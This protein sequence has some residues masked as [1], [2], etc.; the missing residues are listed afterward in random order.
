M[1]GPDREQI[2]NIEQG[3]E[4][5]EQ[6]FRRAVE[7]KDFAGLMQ[8]HNRMC[9]LVAALTAAWS[10]G[11]PTVFSRFYV[12]NR[13]TGQ[14]GAK[15]A[16]GTGQHP[17]VQ[18]GATPVAKPADAAAAAASA[19]AKP[20]EKPVEK[21]AAKPEDDVPEI[22]VL[23]KQLAELAS[24]MQ[25]CLEAGDMDGML[26]ANEKMGQLSDLMAKAEVRQKE[27]SSAA[28]ASVLSKLDEAAE[29]SPNK[30]VDAKQ[31]AP[32]SLAGGWSAGDTLAFAKARAE[33]RKKQQKLADSFESV[34]GQVETPTAGQPPL[35]PPV[36]TSQPSSTVDMLFNDRTKS[37]LEQS[38]A[39]PAPPAPAAKPKPKRQL[40]A[41]ELREKLE[42]YTFYEILAIP[43][44]ASF[45]ELHKAF[46]RKIRKLNK[47]LANKTMDEWQFQELVAALC[48]AHDVLKFP[49]ARLQ[50]D[51]VLF[52]PADGSGPSAETAA[53]QKMMPLKEML[54]FSTLIRIGEL[55]EAIEK[56]KDSKDE[57]EIGHY[58]VN[59]GLLSKEELDS[60]FFAQKLVSAGKLTVAQFELAMQEMREN[61]IPLLDTLVASEWIQ[62]Q[63]V[64]S[65]DFS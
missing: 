19:E 12:P 62:P 55:S 28:T 16:G 6:E 49:N 20:A 24:K 48:L 54:K 30:V 59:K 39:T 50:Y 9:Q 58:L 27:R 26:Q 51:L 56:H 53:K 44:T 35:P 40:T 11:P 64:F 31:G 4:R 17:I 7:A 60:I 63:D 15:G 5:A 37:Q 3:L 61:S 43:S 42:Q 65:T 36:G 2:S 29:S 57:R 18:S 38:G 21:P 52:G 1:S 13:Q 23:E 45:E 10:G 33:E 32:K 8:A 47:K 46:L 14:V 22:S 25:K 41:D 34:V